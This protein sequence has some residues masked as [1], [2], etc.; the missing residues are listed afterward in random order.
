MH[1]LPTI[2]IHCRWTY[3]SI[4]LVVVAIHMCGERDLNVA[5]NLP[6][7]HTEIGQN[8]THT[9]PEPRIHSII[10]SPIYIIILDIATGPIGESTKK[11]KENPIGPRVRAIRCVCEHFFLV[12]VIN[13]FAAPQHCY[14][15]I[16]WT[17]LIRL[18]FVSLFLLL[19]SSSGH[20]SSKVNR[21][22]RMLPSHG[23]DPRSESDGVHLR[24]FLL[25][26]FLGSLLFAFAL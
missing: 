5:A 12:V 15:V 22:A 14:C 21:M 18:L 20:F 7:R 10:W 13:R 16:C 11:E 17:N 6:F 26:L 2:I 4:V 19:V 3:S 8:W 23:P 25:L 1:S 24:Y 9:G